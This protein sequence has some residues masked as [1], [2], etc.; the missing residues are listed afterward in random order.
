MPRR[1]EYGDRAQTGAERKQRERDRREAEIDAMKRQ[2]AAYELTF[3]P[4]PVLPAKE[5]A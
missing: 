5:E 4:L 3:G 2:L 1:P